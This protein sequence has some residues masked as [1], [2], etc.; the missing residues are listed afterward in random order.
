MNKPNYRLSKKTVKLYRKVLS[1]AVYG[2]C[3]EQLSEEEI[4][5]VDCIVANMDLHAFS[6]AVSYYVHG[7]TMQEIAKI[8]GVNVSSV[9]RTIDIANKKLAD[10]L[11]EPEWYNKFR[12]K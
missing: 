10:V 12:L 9:S 2:E 3:K 6:R 4:D 11:H 5:A 8:E 7:K 1:C